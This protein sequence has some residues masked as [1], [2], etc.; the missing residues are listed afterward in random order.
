MPRRE[1]GNV[2]PVGGSASGSGRG[3]ESRDESTSGE[4]R[5]ADGDREDVRGMSRDGTT[6]GITRIPLFP[7]LTTYRAHMLL[8][9]A[10]CI[11]AVDF[12]VFPRTLAK[13]EAFG[14]SIVS[15][16][17]GDA[18]FNSTFLADGSWSWFLCILTGRSLCTTYHQ[19]PDISHRSLL[20][21]D[22][23]HSA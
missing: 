5:G 19:E 22:L 3:R 8:L 12:P 1:S 15:F 10:I 16:H 7:P 20:A 14:V 17:L 6:L 11:L 13:C 2:L 4:R 23:R 9:T 18:C 21:K